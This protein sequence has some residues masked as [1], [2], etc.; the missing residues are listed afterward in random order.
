MDFEVY[1]AFRGHEETKNEFEAWTGNSEHDFTKEYRIWGQDGTGG[2]AALWLTRK[3][4]RTIED[5]PVVFLSS[6]G[7]VGIVSRNLRELL[8]MMSEGVGPCEAVLE[9]GAFGE[10]E[11]DEEGNVDTSERTACEKVREEKE[12]KRLKSF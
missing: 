3:D 6:E 10:P 2:F 8:W 1:D 7:E 4:A 11:E 9:G 12:E 5:Q